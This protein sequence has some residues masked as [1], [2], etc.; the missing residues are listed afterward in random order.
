MAKKKLSDKTQND[1]ANMVSYR[2][3]PAHR[4]KY[5][6]TERVELLADELDAWSKTDDALILSEFASRN[7]FNN[8]IMCK[9]CNE[10]PYFRVS[11]T[12]AMRRISERRE[13]G[14]L[15]K[16]FDPKVYMFTARNYDKDLDKELESRLEREELIKAKAK[17]KALQ[18]E[19]DSK[20]DILKYLDS[21]KI[22][23]EINH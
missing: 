10:N 13:R 12:K 7:D 20:G 8:K 1:L 18:Q 22:V 16:D 4:P 6:T 14:A 11:H 2:K 5:W 9:L 19:L 3:N 21:Q 23:N 15:T 17:I